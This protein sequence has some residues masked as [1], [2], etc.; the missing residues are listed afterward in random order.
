[1]AKI[2]I[3]AECLTQNNTRNGSNAVFIVQ[4][5]TGK[6]K[7][8]AAVTPG[9]PIGA[10]RAINVNFDDDTAKQFKPGESYTI[11]IE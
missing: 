7:A 3:K 4:K 5:D 6:N 11:T 2:T 8:A 9:A 1:M 10:S